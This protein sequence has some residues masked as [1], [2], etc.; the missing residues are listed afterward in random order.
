MHTAAEVWHRAKLWGL[1]E[2]SRCFVVYQ[3]PNKDVMFEGNKPVG[4]VG[5]CCFILPDSGYD[6]QRM[7]RAYELCVHVWASRLNQWNRWNPNFTNTSLGGYE[8]ILP[9]TSCDIRIRELYVSSEEAGQKVAAFRSSPGL[10]DSALYSERKK[11]T[12]KLTEYVYAR[13]SFCPQRYLMM[14]FVSE[15]LRSSMR[16]GETQNLS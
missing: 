12:N 11:I 1:W 16:I 14:S 4:T 9:S 6:R 15:Y 3:L 5:G 8:F 7:L 10:I 13:G 2:F